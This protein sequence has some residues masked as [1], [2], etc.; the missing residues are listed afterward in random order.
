[1]F[2]CFEMGWNDVYMTLII[3]SSSSS[4]FLPTIWNVCMIFKQGRTQPIFPWRP[5]VFRLSLVF[6]YHFHLNNGLS[7]KAYGAHHQSMWLCRV[8]ENSSG[9][10]KL[11]ALWSVSLERDGASNICLGKQFPLCK[12]CGIVSSCNLICY[13]CF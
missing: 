7:A 13:K 12:H 1:M 11:Y 8:D 3:S 2:V 10:S 6:V 5:N 9:S 4:L